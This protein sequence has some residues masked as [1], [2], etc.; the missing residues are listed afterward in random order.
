MEW[1]SRR[2]GT[3]KTLEGTVTSKDNESKVGLVYPGELEVGLVYPAFKN[4]FSL[5]K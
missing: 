3:P 1:V 2:G 5:M 4:G